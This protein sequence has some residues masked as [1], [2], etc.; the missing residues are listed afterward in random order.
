[1][2]EREGKAI[3]YSGAGIRI[4]KEGKKC[5]VSLGSSTFG[6]TPPFAR[7]GESGHGRKGEGGLGHGSAGALSECR[8][9]SVKN[10]MRKARQQRWPWQG[11]EPQDPRRKKLGCSGPSEAAR[12]VEGS[13]RVSDHT[14]GFISTFA[15]EEQERSAIYFHWLRIVA[16]RRL[17]EER[18]AITGGGASDNL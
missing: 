12:A 17:Y 13:E 6:E 1:V 3:D 16:G 8:I 5:S 7:R 10:L 15:C 18:P 14:I 2:L 9:S 4:K 11:G